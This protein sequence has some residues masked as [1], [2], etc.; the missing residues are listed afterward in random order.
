MN[1]N[2]RKFIYLSLMGT[3]GLL[4]PKF[5]ISKTANSQFGSLGAIGSLQQALELARQANILRLNKS[6]SESEL[7]YR[8]AIKL[9]P[10]D[11]R[12]LDGLRKV[13]VVQNR[14]DEVVA[15]YEE[16]YKNNLQ[17]PKF[18][19]RL[20][21][22][23]K[24]IEFGNKKI[25]NNIIS[26]HG[27]SSLTEE[28][29]KLYNIA[30]TLNAKYLNSS[31]L[32]KVN[33][34]RENKAKEKDSR[35]NFMMKSLKKK[36]ENA[37]HGKL[38]NASKDK[39]KAFLSRI[40]SKKR[41]NLSLKESNTRK[42]NISKNKKNLDLLIIRQYKKEFDWGNAISTSENLYNTSQ[43]SHALYTLK[44][45]CKKNNQWDKIIE[46]QKNNYSQKKDFWKGL[47]VMKLVKEQIS[48]TGNL[49]YFNDSMLIGNE[50]LNKYSLDLPKVLKINLMIAK[51]YIIT[52]KYSL[53]ESSLEKSKNLLI[54][55]GIINPLTINEYFSAYAMLF[56]NIGN[57]LK[58]ERIL[59]IGLGIETN[60]DDDFHK[61]FKQKLA[62][63]VSH[64][65]L[66]EITLAKVYLKTDISKA[67]AQLQHILSVYP[68]DKF[69]IKNL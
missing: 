10:N 45:L 8:E 37:Y 16:G 48:K 3:S 11:V 34:F 69:A 56:L 7:K 53:A 59:K 44:K 54:E 5:L 64:K 26:K 17:N 31:S 50:M 13:L 2:R 67:N 66:L 58:A 63:K 4:F 55:N 39:L 18:A 20:G 15:L 28:S 43:D 41:R 49:N 6:Y 65:H 12:F 21:D 47:G 36:N 32:S 60:K 46:I 19:F 25:A 68:N 38:K 9:M 51:S 1:Y 22:I 61:L 40:N 42:Y 57:A 62:E 29:K 23:Y 14:I 30:A 33:A 27:F 24:Q 52:K 35:G